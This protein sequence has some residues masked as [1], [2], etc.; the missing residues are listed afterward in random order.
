VTFLGNFNKVRAH[1]HNGRMNNDREYA[2]FKFYRAL[3][4]IRGWAHLGNEKIVGAT[5]KVVERAH[6]IK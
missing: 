6:R 2:Y 5:K 3:H 4:E 1:T